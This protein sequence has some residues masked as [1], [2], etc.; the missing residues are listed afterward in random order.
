MSGVPVR[1][2]ELRVKAIFGI[3]G[4]VR[5]VEAEVTQAWRA[6][7]DEKRL[8]RLDAVREIGQSRADEIGARKSV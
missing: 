5:H 1:F 3:V 7:E 4:C 6:N 2:G 8:D